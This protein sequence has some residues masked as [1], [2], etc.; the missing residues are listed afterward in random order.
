MALEHDDHGFC[1]LHIRGPS[2]RGRRRYCA[3]S[4]TRPARRAGRS[5]RLTS[6]HGCDLPRLKHVSTPPLVLGAEHDGTFT[7]EEVRATA[8]A[9]RTEAEI[10]PDMGRDM[11]LDPGCAVVAGR[12]DAWLGAR[13]L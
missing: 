9:Y 11:M 4:P 8:R 6:H 3:Y 1:V 5:S 13:D 7:T 2:G 12:I 10:F